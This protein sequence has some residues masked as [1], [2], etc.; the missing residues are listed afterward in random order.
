ARILA[1]H[2]PGRRR[3]C[4]CSE[5]IRRSHGEIP[6]LDEF[7]EPRADDRYRRT[8]AI[9]RKPARRD[10]VD[11]EPDVGLVRRVAGRRNAPAAAHEA[12]AAGE[13]RAEM[14]APTGLDFASIPERIQSEVQRAIMRSIKGVEYFSTSGPTLGSTPKDVLH[15][16][17]TMS[18]Y[19]Y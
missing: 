19:H 12:P 16:R 8:A 6:S 15:S 1:G 18:L 17:G 9:H 13:R 14:N 2:E 10:Q 3:C 4:G 5:A 7:A 11:A